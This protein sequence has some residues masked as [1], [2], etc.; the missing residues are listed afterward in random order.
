MAR[1]PSSLSPAHVA[2]GG[3]LHPALHRTTAQD[4]ARLKRAS[5]AH[6]CRGHEQPPALCGPPQGSSVSPLPAGRRYLP[7]HPVPGQRHAPP[8]EHRANTL[9]SVRVPQGNR[10]SPVT[11]EELSST[12]LYPNHML[13]LAMREWQLHQDAQPASPLTPRRARTTN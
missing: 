1:P 2:P 11:G 13:Q 3:V 4:C 10:T 9:R 7:L 5:D 6:V 12:A 8:R